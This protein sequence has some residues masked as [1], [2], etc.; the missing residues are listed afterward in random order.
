MYV[1]VKDNSVSDQQQNAQGDIV[2]AF[3][4]TTLGLSWYYK[5]KMKATVHL[6]VF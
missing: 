2:C 4:Y 5:Q 1:M 3:I 6:H